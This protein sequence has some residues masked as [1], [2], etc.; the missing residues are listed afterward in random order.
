MNSK[1]Y[2]SVRYQNVFYFVKQFSPPKIHIIF[3][4][5]SVNV[6]CTFFFIKPLLVNKILLNSSHKKRE[7]TPHP[8]TPAPK[9]K[10][11]E[12]QAS[13]CLAM[14]F[15]LIDG[16]NNKLCLNLTLSQFTNNVFIK[17]DAV[18][19]ILCAVASVQV[20]CHIVEL[21]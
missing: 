1:L 17:L 5:F 16:Q 9:E 7:T 19:C 15:F 21:Y 8:P 6:F 13:W 11:K 12:N 3:L 4:A 14:S 18:H 10:L 20:L 2:H